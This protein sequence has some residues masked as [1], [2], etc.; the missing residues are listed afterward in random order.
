MSKQQY[1]VLS[2]DGFDIRFE[3][4]WD[5]VNDAQKALNLWMERY[6]AQGYYSCNGE[7]IPLNELESRCTIQTIKNT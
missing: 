7:R 2:P 6:E 5:S 1:T 3:N 4:V